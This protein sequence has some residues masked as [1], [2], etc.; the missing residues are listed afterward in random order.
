MR[1][2]WIFSVDCSILWD[3]EP[4]HYSS[5]QSPFQVAH[6]THTHCV[7]SA[8]LCL[9]I[10]LA[11]WVPRQTQKTC[12]LKREREMFSEHLHLSSMCT[13]I[14]LNLSATE[15]AV[16]TGRLCT[17]HPYRPFIQI[18]YLKEYWTLKSFRESWHVGSCYQTLKC[19]NLSNRHAPKEHQITRKERDGEV[20]RF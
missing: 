15:Q 16:C 19:M 18:P 12:S 13:V 8:V 2:H 6:H 10:A 20:L 14:W 3:S 1:F 9:K 4:K 5:G 7:N 17:C 11:V